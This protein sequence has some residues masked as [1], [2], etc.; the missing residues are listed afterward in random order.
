[1]SILCPCLT[2]FLF[3][4]RSLWWR[5]VVFYVQD[6]SS[7]LTPLLY[8]FSVLCL[9][10]F[11]QVMQFFRFLQMMHFRVPILCLCLTFFVL[12]MV[13]ELIFCLQYVLNCLLDAFNIFHC[14][15]SLFFIL[16]H[17]FIGSI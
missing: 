6:F 15:C 1:M 2:I 12:L 11:L 9:L 16:F 17:F 7:F 13:W 4:D 5:F 10:L 14:L 3:S 8:M